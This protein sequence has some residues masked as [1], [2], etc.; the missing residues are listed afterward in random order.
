M[1][2]REKI[3][4]A[5]SPEGSAAI[6]AV[7]PYE[8]I[9]IRDH[10]HELTDAPWWHL[11]SPHLDEQMSWRRDVIQKTGQDWFMLP[12]WYSRQQRNCLSIEVMPEGIFRVNAKTG[13]GILLEE[14]RLGGWSTSGQVESY[15]PAHLPQHIEEIEAA[16]P[17]P[18]SFEPEAMLRDGQAELAQALLGEFGR[19]LYPI[20]AV[21]SPFWRCYRLWG[22]EGMMVMAGTDPELVKYACERY[23]ALE[24][25]AAQEAAL[26]GAR[27]IWVEECLTDMISPA[28]FRE[29]ALPHTRKLV[30]AI[31]SL[32]M[33]SIYYYCGDPNDR[34]EELLSTG[35]DA[36]AL[37]EGKKRFRIDI[38]EVVA[39][40]RGR[41]TILGNLDAIGVLQDGS[42]EDLESEISRQLTA[43]R[44][45]GGRFIMSLGS[46]VTPETPVGRVRLY[47]DLVRELEAG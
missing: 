5:F 15:R 3:E 46:P 44:R 13:K 47:C 26:L 29:L 1:T 34:W 22:F 40:V 35:A 28:A 36:L 20:Q 37:E 30:E 31:R 39:R 8:G 45:N 32:G 9:Y 14:P 4:A 21:D 16:I 12:K 38:E 42:E 25:R 19:E 41:C 17:S 6:P 2:G 33:K 11:H 18:P 7:I 24:I 23:L 10:W 27:G 43:G